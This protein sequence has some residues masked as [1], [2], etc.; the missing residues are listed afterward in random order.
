M[1]NLYILLFR[2]E[3]LLHF[4]ISYVSFIFPSFFGSLQYRIKRKSLYNIIY[5]GLHQKRHCTSHEVRS[6]GH[7]VP[8]QSSRQISLSRKKKYILQI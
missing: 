3:N 1:K 5:N 8:P 6:L 7:F 4:L 2:K